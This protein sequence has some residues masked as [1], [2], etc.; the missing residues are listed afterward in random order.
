[1]TVGEIFSFL[2]KLIVKKTKIAVISLIYLQIFSYFYTSK[3]WRGK[4]LCFIVS[5]I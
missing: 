3:T 5:K 4:S 2:R 1:M